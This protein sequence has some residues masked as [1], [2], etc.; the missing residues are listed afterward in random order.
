[1]LCLALLPAIGEELIFRGL[2]LK[3]VA[4]WRN[5]IHAGIWVSAI[6]FSAMHMQ[7]YGFVPR[8]LLGA[9]LGYIMIWSGSIFTSML[10]HFLNNALAI[11]L[12]FYINN[13]KI[14]EKIDTIGTNPGEWIYVLISFAFFTVLMYLM[15]KQSKW[16]SIQGVYFID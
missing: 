15:I 13:D 9:L 3:V 12:N 4:R 10:A 14:S 11:L 5:N 7:F 1:M 16:K 6:V 8:M 2:I